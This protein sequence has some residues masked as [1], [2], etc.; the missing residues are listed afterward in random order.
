MMLAV[1]RTN[2]TKAT[3]IITYHLGRVS[4]YALLGLFGLL[5]SFFYGRFATNLSIFIGVAMI[6][7]IPDKLLRNTIFKTCF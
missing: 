7:V 4:A 3:Q 1:D 2:Q 5:G 6:I